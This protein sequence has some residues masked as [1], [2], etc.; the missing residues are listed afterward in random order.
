MFSFF[1]IKIYRRKFIAYAIFT[2]FMGLILSVLTTLVLL[3]QWLENAQ[4][5]AADAFSRVESILQ[6]DAERI[7]SYLQRVYSNNGLVADV[8]YFLANSAE[9]Y[10]TGRLQ[11][12]LS[13]RF[14]RM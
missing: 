11:N 10:L 14:Q 3:Q 6:N 12:S 9:G 1:Q 2:L 13:H 8:R 7:E 4:N 5:Q